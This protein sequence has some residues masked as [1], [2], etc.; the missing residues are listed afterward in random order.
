MFL[1]FNVLW[2]YWYCVPLHCW[3][4]FHNI[5]NKI[6][7]S[8]H[9]FVVSSLLII[10]NNAVT[11]YSSTSL[12]ANMFSFL[13]GKYL[14]M[15]LLGHTIYIYEGSICSTSGFPNRNSTDVLGRIVICFGGLPTL[16]SIPCHYLQLNLIAYLPHPLAVIT[17]TRYC[18][19]FLRGKNHPLLRITA[20]NSHKHLD[21]QPFNLIILACM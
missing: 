15:W 7:W 18:Q 20:L 8:V 21:C 13:L 2:I 3:V 5:D 12:L 14:E 1:K 16:F 19:M 9:L 4:E 17:Q 11:N 6:C 10:V